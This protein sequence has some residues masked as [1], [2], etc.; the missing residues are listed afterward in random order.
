MEY[1]TFPL[2]QEALDLQSELL[3]RRIGLRSNILHLKGCFDAAGT[4]SQVF[5]SACSLFQISS[6]GELM[7]D[8]QVRHRMAVWHQVCVPLPC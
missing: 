8:S 5:Y 3:F 2:S 1:G 6:S 7:S 4:D